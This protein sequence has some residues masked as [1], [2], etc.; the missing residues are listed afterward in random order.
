MKLNLP[1]T[2]EDVRSALQSAGINQRLVEFV[3]PIEK[4]EKIILKIKQ[5]IEHSGKVL[6]L[7]APPGVGKSTFIQSLTWRPHIKF[8]NFIEV[9]AVSVMS[10]N[11]FESLVKKI[12]EIAE[13]AKKEKEQGPT[14]VVLDYL[15]SLNEYPEQDV[16]G[17][18]R[19]LNGILRKSPLLILWPSTEKHDVEKMLSF[20]EAVSGTI[21][22]DDNAYVDFD[23]PLLDTYPDIAK[24]TISVINGKDISDYSLTQADLEELLEKTKAR[25]KRERTIRNYLKAV[26]SI[27]SERSNY[28]QEMENKIPK[29][30]EIWF[31]FS[32]PTAEEVVGN[33]IRKGE[34]VHEAWTAIGDK[35][36][37]YVQSSAQRKSI[38][39]PQKLQL[40]LTG[41]VKTR[42]MYLPTNSLIS[43]ALAFGQN[44]TLKKRIAPHSPGHWKQKN[45]AVAQL[46]NSPLAKQLQG[47]TVAAGKRK[48]GPAAKALKNATRPFEELVDWVS[49]GGGHDKYVNDAV[50]KGLAGLGF[51]CKTGLDH[52]WIP[53][54]KP[55]ILIEL[56]DKQIC[57]EFHHT[58]NDAQSKIADYVLSK[59]SDYSNQLDLYIKS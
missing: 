42:I 51:S 44:D 43:L 16:K 31:I 11:K 20:A 19:D 2:F 54:I 34:R 13:T 25:P 3:K 5:E 18:F 53:G 56:P 14:L 9:D 21:F 48:G 8:R 23:G 28:I 45:K 37:E 24:N 38:W 17:F 49:N 40:M 27:W 33:F 35:L 36:D 55:D 12:R 32:Y 50:A 59:L 10:G 39:T 30:N 22:S 58:N 4:A 41:S 29:P 15:E 47:E 26:R 52:P 1:H 57:I 46:S 6:F 7:L